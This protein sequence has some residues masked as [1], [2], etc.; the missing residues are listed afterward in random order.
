MSF[1]GAMEFLKISKEE[2]E[3]YIESGDEVHGW[4]V[5]EALIYDNKIS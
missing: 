4:Y 5:D 3:N 2:L 1:S